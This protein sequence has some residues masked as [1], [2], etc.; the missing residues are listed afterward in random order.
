MKVVG[1]K[2]ELIERL[3]VNSQ[4]VSQTSLSTSPLSSAT[5]GSRAV[6]E[7]FEPLS[8]AEVG[9]TGRSSE[10]VAE[11]DKVMKRDNVDGLLAVSF[12]LFFSL[13]TSDICHSA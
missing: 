4:P 6:V 12:P 11:F 3:L 7:E 8:E 9:L 2:Q 13:S 5:V 1:R 10:L